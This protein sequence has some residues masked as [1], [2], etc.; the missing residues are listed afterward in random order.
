MLLCTILIITMPSKIQQ[1][2]FQSRGRKLK[3]IDG[4]E[5]LYHVSRTLLCSTFMAVNCGLK[6][7]MAMEYTDQI[8]VCDRFWTTTAFCA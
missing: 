7:P 5:D 4:V 2:G 8:Q 6:L 3:N 1:S